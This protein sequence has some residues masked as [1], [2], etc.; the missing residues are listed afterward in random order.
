MSKCFRLSFVKVLFALCF[1]IAGFNSSAQITNGNVDPEKKDTIVKKI[2]PEK[3]SSFSEDSLTGTN[4]YLTGLFQYSD[5]T[6]VDGSSNGFYKEWENQTSGFNSGINAGLIMELSKHVH[7][8][9]GISYFG[10]SENYSFKDSLTDSSFTY[11]NTYMQVGLPVRLRFV[12]GEKLQFFAF[13]GIAPLN[14]LN[15]RYNS[16][17]ITE[18]SIA[19][20]RDQE[21]LKSGFASFNLMLS[22]GFGLCYNVKYVGFTIYP[23]FRRNLLNTYSTKTIS[24]NHKMYA[25]GVNV[26]MVFRF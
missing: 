26:G 15:I 13:A 1:I 22:A 17:Y 24:M 7:L 20:V 8:D 2:K 3:E 11:K 10:H 14:I 6:F 16:N 18:D 19:V 5:R 9:I 12:Y 23:E 21:I 25:F 4:F